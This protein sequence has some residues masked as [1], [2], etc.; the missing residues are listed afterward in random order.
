MRKLILAAKRSDDVAGKGDGFLPELEVSDGGG[1]GPK[2]A[3]LRETSGT[4]RLCLVPNARILAVQ[5]CEIFTVYT[6]TPGNP[7]FMALIEKA[8]GKEITTRTWDTV[9]KCAAA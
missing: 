3:R 6:P 8:F 2:M 5:G 9:K 7:V 4:E 1:H